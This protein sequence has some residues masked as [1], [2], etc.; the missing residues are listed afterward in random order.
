MRGL[1]GQASP[2]AFEGGLVVLG[3]FAD[4][5]AQ[6][7]QDLGVPLGIGGAREIG[8]AALDVLDLPGDGAPEPGHEAVAAPSEPVARRD[9][10]DC[11]G[12]LGR[13]GRRGCASGRRSGVRGGFGQ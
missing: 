4:D 1:L 5:A 12:A 11:A 3:E 2:V 13:F 8:A 10:T 6:D 7:R 9:A